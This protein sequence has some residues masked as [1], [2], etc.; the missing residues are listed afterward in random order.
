MA[1]FHAAVDGVE[2]AFAPP[3]Y[4]GVLAQ[5]IRDGAP[6]DVFISAN[7]RY[8]TDLQAAGLAPQPQPLA[9]NRLLLVSRPDLQPP[10]TDLAGFV[11]DG[12]RIVVPPPV[13]PL[14]EYALEMV[15]RAGLAAAMARKRERGEVREHLASLGPWL[16]SGEVDAS[17]LYASMAGSFPALRITE[18]PPDLDIHERVVFAIGVIEREGQSHPLARTFVDWMLGDDGRTVLQEGGFLPLS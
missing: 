5:Q 14:G 11:R 16:E 6:A 9:R 4:S 1:G 8:L 10:L 17:V 12:L 2:A 7:T 18:L 15:D 13:D 3:A